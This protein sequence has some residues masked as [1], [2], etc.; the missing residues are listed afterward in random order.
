M[1][2]VVVTASGTTAGA[3]KYCATIEEAQGICA[4]LLALLKMP[5]EVDVIPI[6]PESCI[7]RID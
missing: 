4:K 2:K 1:Y 6:V 5:V 7:K 3:S